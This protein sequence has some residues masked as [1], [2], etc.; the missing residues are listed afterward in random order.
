VSG[1]DIDPA[2]CADRR[3][4]FSTATPGRQTAVIDIPEQRRPPRALMQLRVPLAD[5]RLTTAVLSDL[6]LVV[7]SAQREGDGSVRLTWVRR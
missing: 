5:V 6:G 7:W 2:L 4:R 1:P 3:L